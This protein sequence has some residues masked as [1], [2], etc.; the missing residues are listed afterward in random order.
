MLDF[1]QA[2]RMMVDGQVR[3]SDVTDPAIITAMLEIPRERFAPDGKAALAYLDLDLPLTDARPGVASRCLLKPMVLA[4]LVQAA[5]VR[6]GD[7]AL[8]VGCGTGYS[9]ALLARLG[10]SVVGLEDNDSLARIAR[11][12]LSGLG[13][14]EV[15]VETGPLAGG[16]AKGGPYAVILI[17]GSIEDIPSTLREQLSERGRLVCVQQSGPVGKAMLYYRTADAFS[18]RPIFDASAT[19]LPG[20]AKPRAFVF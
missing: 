13:I 17:E 11:A 9:A 7:R 6:E 20:F 19:A 15:A 14:A 18:G 10:A 12:T 2:R 1:A 16:F 5:D 4:K 3:T 8:V